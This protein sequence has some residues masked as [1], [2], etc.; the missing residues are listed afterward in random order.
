MKRQKP[1]QNK[2]PS[3]LCTWAVHCGFELPSWSLLKLEGVQ[4]GKQCNFVYK[5][6][7]TKKG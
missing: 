1:A 3:S 5:L 6:R 2:D 4:K 7:F